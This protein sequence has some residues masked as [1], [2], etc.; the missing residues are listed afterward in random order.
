[1]QLKIFPERNFFSKAA[2]GYH[3]YGM[4]SVADRDTP[5]TFCTVIKPVLNLSSLN[6]D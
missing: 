1:M 4:S 2:T 6:I 5:P 3:Y